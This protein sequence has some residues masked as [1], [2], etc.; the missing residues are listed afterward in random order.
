M[1]ESL[2][3][4]APDAM[5]ALLLRHRLAAMNLDADM[6]PVGD[7]WDVRVAVSGEDAAASVRRLVEAEGISSSSFRGR[8]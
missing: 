5:S 1:G 3:I 4:Q 6:I 7:V 8:G 2:H